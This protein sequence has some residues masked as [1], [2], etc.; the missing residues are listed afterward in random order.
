MR[1]IQRER[2]RLL[3]IQAEKLEPQIKAPTLVSFRILIFHRGRGS[4]DINTAC[5]LIA[6]LPVSCLEVYHGESLRE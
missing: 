1:D 5:S 2:E 6:P 4:P 3:L